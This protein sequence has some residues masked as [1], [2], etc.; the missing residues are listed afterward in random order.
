MRRQYTGP[1]GFGRLAS[2]LFAISKKDF[3][4]FGGFTGAEAPVEVPRAFS[5]VRRIS[6]NAFKGGP[7]EAAT[8]MG[9]TDS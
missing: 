6:S 5:N 1:S 9:A 8:A 2:G 7:E 4:T 3:L